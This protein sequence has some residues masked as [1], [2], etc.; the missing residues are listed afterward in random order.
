MNKFIYGNLI[1]LGLIFL[2]IVLSLPPSHAQAEVPL[3][4][5][6]SFQTAPGSRFKKVVWIVFENADYKKVMEQ[7]DFFRISQYGA[8]MTQMF[9]S[10]HPSQGNYI[11]MIAGSTLGVR[12]DSPIDLNAFHLGDL[13][14]RKG[15]S[16]RVYAED[17]PGNCFTGKKSKNYVRKHV[18]FMSFINVTRNPSRCAFIENDQNFNSDF[19]SGNLPN[20]S[21]YIPSLTNDGHNTNVDYAG[22]WLTA[23]FGNLLTHPEALREILFILTFDE[24]SLF[25]PSN[26]IYTVLVGS[27]IIPGSQF[28]PK[29]GHAALLKLI[30]DEYGLGN[31]GREDSTSPS[32]LGIWKK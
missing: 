22:R 17:Y 23:R 32:I 4:I 11:T 5:T 2:T 19:T 6:S 18:P 13:L 20:F 15:L 1:W 8:S 26:Q 25:S 3:Q 30:E 28:S 21:M 31:L 9:A 16:W 24:S 14:E 7:K 12:N 27:Q 29:I 10:T